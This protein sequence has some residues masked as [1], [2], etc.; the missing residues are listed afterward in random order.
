MDLET[1][2]KLRKAF[3]GLSGSDPAH[4]RILQA[5]DSE[6]EGFTDVTDDEYDAIRRMVKRLYGIEYAVAG[7]R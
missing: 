6:C 5:I 4:T 3:L 2:E 1:R 7:G